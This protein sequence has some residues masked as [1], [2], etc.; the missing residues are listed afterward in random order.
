MGRFLM[1]LLLL[2]FVAGLL[3]LAVANRQTVAIALPFSDMLLV[4]PVFFLFG[5]GMLAG[6]LLA[7]AVSL[8]PGFRRML[9]AR[10]SERR[11]KSAEAALAQS[12]EAEAAARRDAARIAIDRAQSHNPGPA[13][14]AS[15]A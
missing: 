14:P 11:A 2:A 9:N 5:F 7:L 3:A 10:K 4:M 12:R 13:L 15:K 1:R 8:R 6:L